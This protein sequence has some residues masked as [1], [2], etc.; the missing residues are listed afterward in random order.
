[1]KKAKQSKQSKQRKTTTNTSK[2]RPP[3]TKPRVLKPEFAVVELLTSIGTQL[4][5]IA[6]ALSRDPKQGEQVESAASKAGDD[7][8]QI[9]TGDKVPTKADIMS[10]SQEDML[11]LAEHLEMA[12]GVRGMDTKLRDRICEELG[13]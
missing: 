3:Q 13:L 2:A 7:I 1:M 4:Q 8:F 5:R 12:K 9:I 11:R 6:D 10:M